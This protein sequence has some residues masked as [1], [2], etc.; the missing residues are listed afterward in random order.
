MHQRLINL[1]KELGDAKSCLATIQ[2]GNARLPQQL[3]NRLALLAER[4]DYNPKCVCIV[5][6]VSPFPQAIEYL[7]KIYG[8]PVFYDEVSEAIEAYQRTTAHRSS[9][10]NLLDDLSLHLFGLSFSLRDEGE[11]AG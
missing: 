11:L 6:G 9:V 3:H 4:L 1:E 10:N 5:G 2:G 8:T 7:Q